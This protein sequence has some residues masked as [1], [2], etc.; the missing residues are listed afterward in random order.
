MVFH[1]FKTFVSDDNNDHTFNVE[2]AFHAGR[3]GLIVY[4]HWTLASRSRYRLDFQSIKRLM[5]V[6]KCETLETMIFRDIAYV[7]QYH[8]ITIP[9]GI[10]AKILKGSTA[11]ARRRFGANM[12]RIKPQCIPLDGSKPHA[13]DWWDGYA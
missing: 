9:E 8:K 10:K 3:K 1:Q 5:N 13:F 12:L 11:T 7:E 4:P 6:L 2:R